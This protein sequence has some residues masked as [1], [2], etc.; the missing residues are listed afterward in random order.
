M[1][2]SEKLRCLAWLKINRESVWWGEKGAEK[3]EL[4]LEQL[5]N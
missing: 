5:Y 3:L 4:N 2:L 1:S